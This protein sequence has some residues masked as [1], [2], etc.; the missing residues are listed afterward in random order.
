[1]EL[2]QYFDFLAADDIRIKGHRIGIETVLYEYL[3]RERTAEEIQQLYPS[4]TLAEVYTTILYYLLNKESV[5]RYIQDWLEWSHQQ[6]KIQAENP[7]PAAERLRKLK[8]ERE[9]QTAIQG[10]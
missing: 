9:K 10:A 4:L 1:M 5:S 2:H 3:H 7:H 8:A 6:R